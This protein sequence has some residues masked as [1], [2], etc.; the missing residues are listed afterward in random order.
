MSALPQI[1]KLVSSQQSE[2]LRVDRPRSE[3][4]NDV[5]GEVVPII[6]DEDDYVYLDERSY[7][8]DVYLYFESLRL[9][10]EAKV[11]YDKL[12]KGSAKK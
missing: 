10:R 11:I 8:R 12:V 5:E 6:I 4:S 9:K 3:G 7:Q 2:Y 1:S